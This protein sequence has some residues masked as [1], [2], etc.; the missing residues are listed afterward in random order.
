LIFGIA[1]SEKLP[2]AGYTAQFCVSLLPVAKGK[3]LKMQAVVKTD[4]KGIEKNI[5]FW[6]IRTP[7][8]TSQET[9][10]FSATDHS[11]LMLCKI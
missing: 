1:G 7:V 11:Q 3:G 6:D 4:E 10:H 9:H 8:R 2:V 5:I